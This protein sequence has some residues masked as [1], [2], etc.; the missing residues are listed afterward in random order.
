MQ[1]HFVRNV[2]DEDRQ[3]SLVKYI[4]DG[5][6]D[7]EVINNLSGLKTFKDGVWK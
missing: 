7:P 1:I 6:R 3:K 4:E 5:G 2:T